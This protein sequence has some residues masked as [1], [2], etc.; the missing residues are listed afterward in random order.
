MYYFFSVLESNL[1][2]CR[3]QASTLALSSNPSSAFSFLK[4]DPFFLCHPGFSLDVRLMQRAP[5][6][7]TTRRKAANTPVWGAIKLG[8]GVGMYFPPTMFSTYDEF[9]GI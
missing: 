9:I 6:S 3:S 5:S 7:L 2:P 4:M 8:E 1:G